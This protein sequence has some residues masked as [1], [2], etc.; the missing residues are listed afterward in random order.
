MFIGSWL[1]AKRSPY[2]FVSPP[3]DGFAFCNIHYFEYNILSAYGFVKKKRWF[4]VI[5]S[6][7]LGK[8]AE[9]FDICCFPTIDNKGV[10]SVWTCVYACFDMIIPLRQYFYFPASGA[11]V[12]CPF[13]LDLSTSSRT[14][15]L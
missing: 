9:I 6:Y 11:F 3:C 10:Y 13:L 8:T 12:Y 5:L 15:V 7:F 4:L 14:G 1:T 2:S